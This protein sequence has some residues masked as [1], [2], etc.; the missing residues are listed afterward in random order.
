MPASGHSGWQQ[1]H[2]HLAH[3][4]MLLPSHVYCPHRGI[5]SEGSPWHCLVRKQ[6]LVRVDEQDAQEV[7]V[8]AEHPVLGLAEGKDA[9]V[10]LPAAT[11]C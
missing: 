1:R 2:E 11:R 4:A 3:T 10:L 5:S 9:S 8:G 6:D 7:T